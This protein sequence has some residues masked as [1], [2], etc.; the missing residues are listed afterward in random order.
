M[1]EN[2]LG[3]EKIS[4]LLRD[5]AIPSITASLVGSLYNIVDQIFIGQGVGYLGNAATNVS[6]PFSTICLAISLLIGIGSASRFSLYLGN[7]EPEPAARAA[8]NGISMMVIMG[9]AYLVIGESLLPQLLKLF[10]ATTEV[11]PYAQQ[12]ASV[13]LVGMPFLIITNGMS[14]LIR[15]DG[16]PRYSMG[17]MLIGAIANTILDPIFIFAFHWGIFG[18]ALATILGQILSFA[19]A[20][21]YLWRFK[22]IHF[23]KKHFLPDIRE[24]LK[25]CSMGISSSA[26]Q[27]AITFVQIILYNSLTYYGAQTVYGS[28]IPLAACGIVMK[29]NA[30]ILAIVVGISQGAQPIIGFNY[31]AKQYSRVREAYLLAIKWNMLVSAVGFCLLQCFPQHIISLF[32]GEDALYL[33]FAVL[34]MRIYLFMVLVNGVQLLS[35]SFFTAIGKAMKGALLALT[36]QVFFLIP[37]I[38]VLPLR[39][40]IMGVLYAGPI[41]DFSA[42]MLSVVLVSIEFKKQKMLSQ[43]KAFSEQ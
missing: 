30:I 28:D 34:F 15:A 18:A 42:F 13:T 31:G 10:G 4:K 27:I 20:V 6:Y 43:K 17:C 9:L 23:E 22:T 7:K 11:Y 2:P 26:N 12:Y 5:F 24:S 16:S 33:E 39:F 41:A 25:T 14:N 32:G 36:R 19:F 3:Y 21:R 1:T 8:G 35:S 38:L 29:T 40:G 37:L